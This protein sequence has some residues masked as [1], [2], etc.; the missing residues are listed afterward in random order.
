MAK[1]PDAMRVKAA[2]M[3]KEFAGRP[4]DKAAP[5]A[6]PVPR[7]AKGGRVPDSYT[8]YAMGGSVKASG[9]KGKC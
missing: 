2:S 6:A 1:K 5:K 7:F 9:R 8:G 4:I 3:A